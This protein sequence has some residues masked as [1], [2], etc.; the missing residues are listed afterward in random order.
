MKESV[1]KIVLCFV[2]VFCLFVFVVD[3]VGFFWGGGNAKCSKLN[4]NGLTSYQFK[5][6]EIQTV[7][8]SINSHQHVYKLHRYSLDI[9]RCFQKNSQIPYTCL[10][11]E[12]QQKIQVDTS[13]RTYYQLYFLFI[14]LKLAI[15]YITDTLYFGVHTKFRYKL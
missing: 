11:L 12:F 8:G 13:E 1:R 5:F 10:K 3:V 9:H 7:L 6:R 14:P 4:H 2:F 15:Y